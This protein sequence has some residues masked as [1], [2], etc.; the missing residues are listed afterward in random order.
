MKYKKQLCLFV[1]FTFFV[2]P[3]VVNANTITAGNFIC[4]HAVFLNIFIGILEG[5]LV[6]RFCRVA[7]KKAIG[8]LLLANYVS[9]FC[10]IF[11]IAVFRPIFSGTTIYNVT[12]I[13][14][15][16]WVVFYLVTVLIEWPVI[17]LLFRKYQKPWKVSLKASFLAQT[18]S[19]LLLLA[20][21]GIIGNYA[22]LYSYNIER[23]LS[24]IKETEAIVYYISDKDGHIYKMDL[25]LREPELIFD[26]VVLDNYYDQLYTQPDPNG[27]TWDLYVLADAQRFHD[28]ESSH[29]GE[30]QGKRILVLGNISRV[31]S[32]DIET[33]S[34]RVQT[35][36]IDLREEEEKETFEIDVM[37]IPTRGVYVNGFNHGLMALDTPFFTWSSR[38]ATVLPGNQ[39]VFQ[40]DR[41]ICIYDRATQKLGLLTTGRRPIVGFPTVSDIH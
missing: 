18:I 35:D 3:Q 29:H 30:I 17:Y 19:Y 1:F 33:D 4:C 25:N 39:V 34:Y 6:A 41:Q 22:F 21:Y 5:L 28:L 27:K 11:L 23:D 7:K 38:N 10:G 40:L 14:S 32:F 31:A 15:F 16:Y 2:F 8:W 37:A 9:S 24:F 13:L 20:L 36:Y 26:E 12:W